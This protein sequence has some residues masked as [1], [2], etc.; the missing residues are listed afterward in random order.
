MLNNLILTS[1]QKFETE[2]ARRSMEASEQIANEMGAEVHDDLIQ[3]LTIFSLYLDRLERSAGLPDE[4]ESLILKMRADF[5]TM[6]R[7]VRTIS[8]QLMPVTLAGETFNHNVA[9]LCENLDMPDQGQVHFESSGNELEIP[10]AAKKYLYRII[11]ELIHNAFKHSAAWHVWVTLLWS[12]DEL[13][14]AV[15][16]DGTA[17]S[18]MEQQISRLNRKYN[19]LKMR[20]QAIGSTLSYHQGKKGLLAKIK[21]RT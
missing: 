11:Q 9:T 10:E 21:Y 15:E 16:D 1:R 14:V 2:I 4:V 12:T 20:S 13:M 17:F 6:A 19:T 8:R 3:K 5:Q 18:T 7:S